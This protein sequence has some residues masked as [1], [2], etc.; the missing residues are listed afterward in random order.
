MKIFTF[1]ALFIFCTLAA[2]NQYTCIQNSKGGEILHFRNT[3]NTSKFQLFHGF[4]TYE[5]YKNGFLYGHKDLEK[6]LF[7]FAV[8]FTDRPL[9]HT[10]LYQ[11]STN[12]HGVQMAVSFASKYMLEKPSESKFKVVDCNSLKA[13]NPSS[14]VFGNNHVSFPKE[15]CFTNSR[16]SGEKWRLKTVANISNTH[17]LLGLNSFY[18]LL[19]RHVIGFYNLKDNVVTT[20]TMIPSRSCRLF[21]FG[22][23][24]GSEGIDY[25]FKFERE[26]NY[27]G[28]PEIAH[29]SRCE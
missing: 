21:V 18:G 6:N 3:F 29:F 9:E 20:L 15:I 24:E 25:E 22:D 8:Y 23:P 19:H 7:T 5:G 27:R 11:F 10:A 1:L 2:A 12:G 26:A 14:E 4:T 13:S 17:A 16:W 28:P